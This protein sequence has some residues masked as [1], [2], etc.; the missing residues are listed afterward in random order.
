MKQ[1]GNGDSFGHKIVEFVVE[2]LRLLSVA[3]KDNL[4]GEKE[5]QY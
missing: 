5:R 1:K 3:M 2:Y 4:T